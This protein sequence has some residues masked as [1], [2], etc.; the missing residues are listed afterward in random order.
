MFI[1]TRKVKLADIKQN[2]KAYRVRTPEEKEIIAHAGVINKDKG[3]NNKFSI[4]EKHVDDKLFY[5]VGD[6]AGRLEALKIANTLP[7]TIGAFDELYLDVF[8]E[9]TDKELIAIQMA[10]NLMVKKCISPDLVSGLYAMMAVENLTYSELSAKSGYD[11][12]LL[13]KI[14]RSISIN[15][16]LREAMGKGELTV[17][18]A[19][20]IQE[21][22]G[23]IPKEELP[24]WIEKGKTLGVKKIESDL[25]LIQANYDAA[26]KA[27]KEVFVAL[28]KFIGKDEL[29]KKYKYFEMKNKA[30]D[31]SDEDQIVYSFLKTIFQMDEDSV[32][33]AEQAFLT[34]KKDR[35]DKA[36]N[37]EN[38]KIAKAVATAANAGFKVLGADGKEIPVTKPTVTPVVP[39]PVTQTTQTTKTQV[40]PVKAQ[41]R[42][43]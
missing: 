31:L 41:A 4:Y 26:K 1:E 32:K 12:N 13:R 25:M 24:A 20:K 36:K 17:D 6:G 11:E 40:L 21:Y 27:G 33:K 37:K 42:R 39:T 9:V 5:V 18:K 14:M 19:L 34:A 43:K 2:D 16:L 38:E 28:P 7:G 35:A 8:E 15:T 23:C 22:I 29:Q 10:G 30:N 3:L